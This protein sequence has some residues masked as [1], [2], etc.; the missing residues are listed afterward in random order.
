MLGHRRKVSTLCLLYK[1]YTRVAY[2]I[3]EY[4]NNFIVAD[5][6]RSSAAQD[7]LV[8]VIL[9]CRTDRFNRSFLPADVR[10]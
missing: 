3:N 2:P 4:L 5:N 9:R 8:L 6:T 1:I 10:R 7:E